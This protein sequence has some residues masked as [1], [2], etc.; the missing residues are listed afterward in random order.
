M[1][2]NLYAQ[3]EVDCDDGHKAMS[4]PASCRLRMMSG[5][6]D[7]SLRKQNKVHGKDALSVRHDLLHSLQTL[8]LGH[9]CIFL[10]PTFLFR[11]VCSVFYFLD[12]V[13]LFFLQL[14]QQVFSYEHFCISGS[15]RRIYLN[16]RQTFVYVL[17]TH[18]MTLFRDT[19][20]KFLLALKTPLRSRR[21]VTC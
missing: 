13:F 15:I 20:C 3:Y 16:A 19:T 9:V 7:P 4:R 18:L 6:Q 14:F 17:E 12:T 2:Y 5:V 11:S 10:P 1:S 8:V 21:S